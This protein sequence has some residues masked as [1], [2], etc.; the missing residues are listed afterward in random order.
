MV[1]EYS[2][3]EGGLPTVSYY[4]T[5]TKQRV[6]K[7]DVDKFSQLSKT[8]ANTLAS[9][10][11]D[12]SD[13]QL[14]SEWIAAG[15]TVSGDTLSFSTHHQSLKK[16]L[17]N[18]NEMLDLII[19]CE[20]DNSPA[21]TTLL[22]FILSQTLRAQDFFTNFLKRIGRTG[23]KVKLSDA[24]AEAGLTTWFLQNFF[25]ENSPI[26]S[27]LGSRSF[28]RVVTPKSLVFFLQKEIIHPEIRAE[29]ESLT[30]TLKAAGL[31][32]LGMPEIVDL[33]T[34]PEQ[35]QWNASPFEQHIQIVENIPLHYYSPE[36]TFEILGNCKTDRINR[37]VDFSYPIFPGS[38]RLRL[39]SRALS[40][41]ELTGRSFV[42]DEDVT[43]LMK[44]L[45][46][47]DRQKV[48]NLTEW[49]SV[50][51]GLTTAQKAT[52][53]IFRGSWITPAK[54]WIKLLILKF[55]NKGLARCEEIATKIRAEVDYQNTRTF[56]QDKV[57]DSL[58][59]TKPP[60]L[61]IRKASPQEVAEFKRFGKTLKPARK[62]KSPTATTGASFLYPRTKEQIKGTNLNP[63]IVDYIGTIQNEKL[64]LAAATCALFTKAVEEEEEGS[65]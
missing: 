17:K 63:A 33:L 45:P 27:S 39:L 19:A 35:A 8:V 25:S 21:S 40:L 54:A 32:A 58:K 64:Q 22:G 10:L 49:P 15:L 60:E 55:T 13:D 4:D 30:S 2:L 28:W 53:G 29:I 18:M 61:V 57:P 50:L 62:T 34:E 36:H 59:L 9:Q 51:E 3:A 43:E 14:I 46:P 11:K 31:P 26:E 20:R 41:F 5:E 47:I 38:E 52:L 56:D 24:M 12:T 37:L 44:H 1:C 7:A 6:S 16:R 48:Y 65:D 42:F 23:E